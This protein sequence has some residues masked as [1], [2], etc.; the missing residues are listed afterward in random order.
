MAPNHQLFA[1]LQIVLGARDDVKMRSF[2]DV[3]GSRSAKRCRHDS[4]D[5]HDERIAK[6]SR[7]HAPVSQNE[8]DDVMVA[9][10]ES[11]IKEEAVSMVE[12]VND[13]NDYDSILDEE[14]SL[15]RLLAD[16]KAYEADCSQPGGVIHGYPTVAVPPGQA[17]SVDTF[18][19]DERNTEIGPDEN[20]APIYATPIHIQAQVF[21]DL[22]SDGKSYLRS[23]SSLLCHFHILTVSTAVISEP[24]EIVDASEVQARVEAFV[25]CQSLTHLLEGENR[26]APSDGNESS[27]NDNESL[28]SAFA[29]DQQAENAVD[30][31]TAI[32]SIE[33]VD[34]TQ[35]FINTEEFSD[36]GTSSTESIPDT[37]SIP[38]TTNQQSNDSFNVF[39]GG[40]TSEESSDPIDVILNRIAAPESGQL[41]DIF[42]DDDARSQPEHGITTASREPEVDGNATLIMAGPAT[43]KEHT[44]SDAD[45]FTRRQPLA[46]IP[47]QPLPPVDE[48]NTRDASI[49]AFWD[50]IFTALFPDDNEVNPTS[51]NEPFE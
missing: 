24:T 13:N 28:G 2:A 25:R 23:T 7:V 45:K 43:L 30:R 21:G 34:A 50:R 20:T 32:D 31:D 29:F 33:P 14:D 15:N 47:V 18:S 5:D 12:G 8:D 1:L 26:N 46:P 17:Q 22:S 37:E 19:E 10:P 36:G 42:V 40:M 48:R 38:A 51:V 35:I 49:D 4:D 3:Q 41:F 27:C 11:F 16:I 9:A 39:V 6:R 44:Q